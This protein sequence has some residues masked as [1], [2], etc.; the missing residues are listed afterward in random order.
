MFSQRCFHRFEKKQQKRRT[1]MTSNE[2]NMMVSSD[3]ENQQRSSFKY[4]DDD[5]K[6][7]T[8]A[9]RRLRRLKRQLLLQQ[10][11]EPESPLESFRDLIMH[12]T[13]PDHVP[14]TKSDGVFITRNRQGSISSIQSEGSSNSFSPP[15]H[16]LSSPSA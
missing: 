15:R 13:A 12:I 7:L 6:E 2:H 4:N 3:D 10:V 16:S 14:S 9:A 5:R 8:N 11:H 1:K